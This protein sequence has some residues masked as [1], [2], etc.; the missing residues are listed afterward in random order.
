MEEGCHDEYI[1]IRYSR[2]DRPVASKVTTART[3]TVPVDKHPPMKNS[4][5]PDVLY[6]SRLLVESIHGR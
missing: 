2:I 6:M 1:H 5:C 3:F 4:A